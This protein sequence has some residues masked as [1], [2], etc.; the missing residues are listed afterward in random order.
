[1]GRQS[2][3]E[4]LVGDGA[5]EWYEQFAR[6]DADLAG[7]LRSAERDAKAAGRGLWSECASSGPGGESP[8]PTQADATSSGAC[9]AAY[10]DDCIPA[11][12]PD[13]DCPD[14]KRRLRVDHSQGDPHGFDANK[15]GWGCESYG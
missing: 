14:I 8:P 10:P 12:P 11:V 9:H 2:V 15:D 13:L 4:R 3:N 5:A 6:E 7:R 1:V